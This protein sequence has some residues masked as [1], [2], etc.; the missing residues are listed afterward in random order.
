MIAV[1]AGEGNLP[2]VIINNFYKKK[3]NFFLINLRKKKIINKKNIYNL[4]I[5]QI[6]KILNLLKKNNCKEVILAG[7]VSR[8]SI[9]DFKLD[10]QAIKLLP[11]LIFHLKKGDSH[12]LDFVINFL[13]KNKINVIS[14]LKYL[15]E[16]TADK[17]TSPIK[18]SN[19]EMADIKKGTKLLNHINSN[20]DVGQSVVINNGFVVGIEAAEGT[21]LMLNKIIPIQKKINK[22][23]SLSGVLIKM[24]KKIQDIRVDIPTI[25][26]KTIQN[27]LKAGIR[28]IAL[29]KNEN[30]FLDQEKSL[31]LIKQNN[32][33]IKVIN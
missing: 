20:F 3:V 12:V 33:F 21:D 28:G 16:I 23:G 27:C 7:K 5:T 26:L 6:S 17:F 18:I 29:K 19:K 14:C 25:G 2:K 8:P 22:K 9:E 30:I 31:K 4:N 11:K 1:I 13:K 10:Y 15:P 24:P 32:F